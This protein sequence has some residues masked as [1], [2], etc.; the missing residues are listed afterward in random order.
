MPLTQAAMMTLVFVIV[1]LVCMIDWM[2]MV[3]YGDGV[4][5]LYSASENGFESVFGFTLV[6]N[7]YTVGGGRLGNTFKAMLSLRYRTISS[8]WSSSHMVSLIMSSSGM[9]NNSHAA[10]FAAK[11]LQPNTVSPQDDGGDSDGDDG[12]TLTK[13][14]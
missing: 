10:S 12:A 13:R 8:W 6:L 4:T 7:L 9:P 2:S 14:S 3:L 5:Y 11:I 1:M